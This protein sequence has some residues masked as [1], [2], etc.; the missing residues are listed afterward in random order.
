MINIIKSIREIKNDLRNQ[1]DFLKI[2]NYDTISNIS[3]K[4][5]LVIG[6]INKQ[7]EF[8]NIAFNKHT[9]QFGLIGWKVYGNDG[10]LFK[11]MNCGSWHEN[12]T[13]VLT[14]IEA[15]RLNSY[16][17]NDASWNSPTVHMLNT[18]FEK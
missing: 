5:N 6:E 7:S 16:E 14:V 2:N 9:K 8:S 12:E 13:Q 11:I 18:I 17:S 3:Q 15:K 1:H 10:I 4:L